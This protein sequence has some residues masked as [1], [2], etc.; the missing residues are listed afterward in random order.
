MSTVEEIRAAIEQLPATQVIRIQ[1]WLAEYAERQWDEQ[2]ER[3][4][5]SG[6]LDVLI[7]R[8]SKTIKL[9]GR[10]RCELS[11]N[12]RLLGKLGRHPSLYL[13]QFRRLW[14]VRVGMG[15]RSLAADGPHD[16]YEQT[17]AMV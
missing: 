5:R 17:V 1:E 12:G 7:N 16:K 13:K 4:G 11:D 3:V 8:A 6:R 14:S 9:G 10:S 15:Y 2:I